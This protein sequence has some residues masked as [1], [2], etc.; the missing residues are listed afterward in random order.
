MERRPT[1]FKTGK[2][3]VSYPKVFK[4]EA[5]NDGEKK[6]YS[7]SMLIPKSD[8]KTLK[9]I[10]KAVESAIEEGIKNKW[11]GKRP[12]KLGLPLRDGD[13]EKDGEEYEGAM[14]FNA[15]SSRKPGVIDLDKDELFDDEEFYPGC[16]ARGTFNA[17][18][19]DVNGNK[20]VAIGLNNLQKLA[21]GDRLGGGSR[22][23]ESDFDDE[24]DED[25]FD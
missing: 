8:K 9:A 21:D 22:S 18:P 11:G 13:E 5:M 15:S 6:K 24:W 16:F 2:C 10:E 4:P 12:K 1:E 20:G 7:V 23:A 14:F 17:Y 19:F 25:D 3:R